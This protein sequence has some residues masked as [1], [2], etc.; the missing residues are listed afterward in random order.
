MFRTLAYLFCITVVRSGFAMYIYF[1]FRAISVLL[2]EAWKNL[3]TEERE[4]FSQ[5][6][7]VCFNQDDKKLITIKLPPVFI[8]D[9]GGRAE[10]TSPRL[11]EEEALCVLRQ[12]GPRGQQR[13]RQ[14]GIFCRKCGQ[15]FLQKIVEI[16][17]N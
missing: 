4:V 3:Q 2:G 6:A 9:S 12:H 15:A 7:K 8:S 5:K 11:L 17:R 1:L 10:E 16:M 13:T 14:G